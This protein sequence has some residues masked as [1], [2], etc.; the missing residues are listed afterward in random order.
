MISIRVL[1]SPPTVSKVVLLSRW[2]LLSSTCYPNIRWSRACVSCG[3]WQRHILHR[4]IF[5]SFTFSQCNCPADTDTNQDS[6][7][8]KSDTYSKDYSVITIL[9]PDKKHGSTE[10][11]LAAITREFR[12]VNNLPCNEIIG[13]GILYPEGIHLDIQNR[14]TII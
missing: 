9:L 12:L 13:K 2:N 1:P 3:D 8:W 5:V 4:Q 11:C 10:P 14:K 7:F 6:R